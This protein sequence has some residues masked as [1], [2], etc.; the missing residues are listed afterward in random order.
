MSDLHLSLAKGK[1]GCLGIDRYLIY[2]IY[3]AWQ[4]GRAEGE[5][6]PAKKASK[7]NELL[8]GEWTVEF[9]DDRPESEFD[10]F[11]PEVQAK[12]IWIQNLIVEVGLP[13]VGKP[14][15]EQL[16]DKIWEIRAEGKD[17]WGRSLYCTAHGRRVIILRCFKKKS[18]KTPRREIMIAKSR[19]KDIE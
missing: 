12:T 6:V 10:E 7:F 11:S 8:K 1:I 14:Y 15:V 13:H 9:L 4:R 3:I 16:E 17:G 5:K 18:N 19:M 2:E